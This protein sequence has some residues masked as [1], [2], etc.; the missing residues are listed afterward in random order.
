MC[1]FRHY[2]ISW[3]VK[4]SINNLNIMNIKGCAIFYSGIL[5]NVFLFPIFFVLFTLIWWT[6]NSCFGVLTS[7]CLNF[8]VDI[9]LKNHIHVLW[10]G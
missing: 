10:N 3:P 2:R 9:D 1:L 6:Y 8:F 4:L 7:C 5:L